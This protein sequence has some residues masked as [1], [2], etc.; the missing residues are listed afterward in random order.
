MG[1]GYL[2]G[3][4]GMVST[5]VAHLSDD[6]R[7]CSGK[8]WVDILWLHENNVI[9][10][11]RGCLLR[12]SDEAKLHVCVARAEKVL[13]RTTDVRHARGLTQNHRR[14]RHGLVET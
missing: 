9:M 3:C 8:N 6:P 5:T 13:S 11:E 12:Y 7:Y 10:C 1:I 4:S 14:R 2:Y